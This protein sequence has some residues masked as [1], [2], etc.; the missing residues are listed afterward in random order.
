MGPFQQPHFSGETLRE[1]LSSFMESIALRGNHTIQ[2]RIVLQ[3]RILQ[4]SLVRRMAHG[5]LPDK[6]RT[7]PAYGIDMRFVKLQIS[8]E[9]RLHAAIADR[10]TSRG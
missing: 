6:C 5:T 1:Q 8:A 3:Q 4:R 10:L 2:K 9:V 7:Q